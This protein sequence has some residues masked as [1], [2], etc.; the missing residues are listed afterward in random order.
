MDNCSHS[1]DLESQV[2]MK[3][4]AG[5]DE[6]GRGPLAGP[7]VAAAV[8]LPENHTIEGLRDSKKLS[9]KMRSK[10]FSII[11]EHA[12]GI[13]VGQASVK[14]IDKTNIRTATMKAMQMALGNL[15]VKPDKALIDGHPLTNQIIPN[16]GIIRGDNQI[17][18]IKA[19]SII[20]KVTRDRMMEEYGRIFPEYG[21]Q[22][23][24]GYGTKSHMKALSDF[25][26]TPIH[27]RT[28]KPV[29]KS[30][31]TLGWLSDNRRIGWMGEKLAALYLKQKGLS[32]LEMNRNCHPYG[33]IDVI[34]K[35]GDES[36]FVEVKTAY[37]TDA[38]QIDKKI[39]PSKLGK[40]SH[41]IQVYQNETGLIGDFRIDGISV[42]LN[43]NRPVIKHFEGIRLD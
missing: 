41:A 25:K 32:V 28:F 14:T 9:A 29:S 27:R 38:S 12:D 30:M 31:P 20:A 43:K 11:H 23:H 42:I 35:F 39:D 37:K 34:A 40:L 1:V 4:I 7:V 15:P 10:L 36:I 33:E 21:F 24:K 26:A 17:D 22:K 16:E 6:A 19:A 8:I 18:S 2:M 3:I 13:G 5:V